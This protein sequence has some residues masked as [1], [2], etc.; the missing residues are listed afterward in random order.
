VLLALLFV[1][2]IVAAFFGP[3]KYAIRR[4]SSPRRACCSAMLW[5]KA[6]TFIAILLGTIA[7]MVI[8]T[9]HGSAAVA[10]L[11][12]AVALA[13]WMTSWGI[14][15][16]TP[17]ARGGA[18]HWT[19]LRRDGSS[20]TAGRTGTRAVPLNARHLMVLGWPARL[21]YRNFRPMSASSSERKRP[22]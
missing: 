20:D 6:G 19:L 15:P 9:R 21:T 13:A 12:V 5:S 3:L 11:I 8:A 22:S 10:G 14:P 4:I 18:A 17:A 7:G 2:G 16:T 1:M